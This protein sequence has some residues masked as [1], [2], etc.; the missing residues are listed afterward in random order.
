VV[1]LVVHGVARDGADGRKA[2]DEKNKKI[3]NDYSLHGGGQLVV[4][5]A[6]RGRAISGETLND[7]V[8]GCRGRGHGGRREKKR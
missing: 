2:C 6:A 3:C 5:L 4:M 8:G 7:V 1:L